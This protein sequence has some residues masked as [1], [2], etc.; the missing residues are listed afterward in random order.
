MTKKI[1]I[2]AAALHMAPQWSRIVLR[3]AVSLAVLAMFVWLL[4]VRLAH[5]DLIDLRDGIEGVALPNWLAAIAATCVSFWAVGHYDAVLHRHFATGLPDAFTRRA[6]ICAI[7][8]SQTIGLGVISGAI[9]RWRMLP[10]QSLWLATRLTTAVAVSFLAGWAVVTSLVLV[11]L[12]EAEYKAQ[13]SAGLGVAALAMLVC[14]LAPA[15]KIPWP[16]GLTLLRLLLLTAVDTVMAAVALYLLCTDTLA[17]PFATLLPAFLLAFGAGLISGAPG[18]V[19]P[20]EITLLALLPD[21]PEVS[22]LVAVLAWRVV[23]Y[24]V[25]ALIGAG[26]AIKGTKVPKAAP[27]PAPVNLFAAKRAETGLLRQGD[28]QLLQSGTCAWVTGQ[29]QHCLIALFD[30]IAGTAHQAIIAL[31]ASA[32]AQSRLPVVYK[33]SARHAAAARKAG[34]KAL[35]IAREAW[36]DPADFRLE[37]PARAKLRRKLRHANTAG[38]Q[39]SEPVQNQYL[40]WDSLDQIAREWVELH[41]AERG[42]SMG[43]YSRRYIQAQR[44]FIAC[45]DERP[46]AFVSFHTCAEEWALDLMRHGAGLPDGTMHLLIL[47]AIQAAQAEGVPRLSLASITDLP[48]P[49]RFF[50]VQTGLV[51]FKSCFAPNW[52][53]L[54]L[55]APNRAALA[56]AGAE[57][58]RAVHWPSQLRDLDQDH[59][60]YGFATAAPTWHRQRE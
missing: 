29:S 17:L 35:R 54:Y 57:I 19:G 10:G 22:L 15:G 51:R 6:G 16:N 40:D 9:L 48:L 27:L 1:K 5:I 38:V 28:H 37:I 14:V 11:V 45:K 4:S 18:G 41:G 7:A 24:A 50:T 25:P 12:P 55:L 26:F 3:A 34:M 42:F 33:T 47:H 60:D 44:I 30:P 58:A 39:I 53:P 46:V 36:V 13:A 8:V 31:K 2:Q 52:Q 56:L 32:K 49:P 59:A 43:R 23:Y 20:F 21:Q